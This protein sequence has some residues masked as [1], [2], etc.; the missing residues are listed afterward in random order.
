MPT[1]FSDPRIWQQA[2]FTFTV[3]SSPISTDDRGNSSSVGTKISVLF[4]LKPAGSGGIK[5]GGMDKGEASDTGSPTYEG[6]VVAIAGNYESFR[7]QSDIKLG[8]VGEGQLNGRDCRAI[9]KSIAQSGVS[10]IVAA[11]LG[12]ACQLEIDY[13]IRR[14]SQA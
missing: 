3:A 11:I 13:R 14:G 4:K 7:L 9:L 10:P 2:E 8:D 5:Q 6:R 1:P 12:D